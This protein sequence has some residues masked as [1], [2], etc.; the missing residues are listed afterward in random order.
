MSHKEKDHGVNNF[1][2]S[3][4]IKDQN[5]KRLEQ[6]ENLVEKHTRTERHLEQHSDIARPEAIAHSEEI[7]MEREQAI[8]NLKHIIIN[9]KHSN[10]DEVSN[11]QRNYE[12]T[13]SYIEANADR[14]D[15]TTLEYTK[16]KQKNRE[17]Q[18]NNILNK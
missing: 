3:A 17:E 7:Q 13:N 5:A 9:G 16:E 12:F 15:S 6:L 2:K 10:V 14:M 8:D 4:D 18:L 1:N 11:L